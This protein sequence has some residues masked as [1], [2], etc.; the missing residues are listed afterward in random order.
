MAANDGSGNFFY[1]N[2]G[3]TLYSEDY[4]I[5]TRE[6]IISDIFKDSYSGQFYYVFEITD[7]QGNT[8][9]TEGALVQVSAGVVTDVIIQ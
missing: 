8:I 9:E 6:P 1:L 4:Q 5:I 2:I 7:V 3:D